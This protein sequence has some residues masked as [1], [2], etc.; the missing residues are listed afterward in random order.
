MFPYFK[1][2]VQS[3]YGISELNMLYEVTLF[4]ESCQ[5]IA[6]IEFLD[7]ENQ[8]TTEIQTVT[9]FVI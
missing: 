8:R 9:L 7:K 4:H 3:C 5:L 1:H 6:Q 2:V